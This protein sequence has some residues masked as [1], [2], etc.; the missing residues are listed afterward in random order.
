MR[1]VRE[2]DYSTKKTFVFLFSHFHLHGVC[3]VL[4][5]F[6]LFVFPVVADCRPTLLFKE[7]GFNLTTGFLH[8]NGQI[9][10]TGPR[11]EFSLLLKY[12]AMV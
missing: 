12:T 3:L 5:F 8:I 10:I 4:L 2:P 11:P 7:G 6:L 9:K 1:S